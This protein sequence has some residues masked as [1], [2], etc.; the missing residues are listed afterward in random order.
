MASK[1]KSGRGRHAVWSILLLAAIALVIVLVV[2]PWAEK[3]RY[4]LAYPEQIC[5]YAEEFAL[6][7]YLV[8]AVIHCESGNRPDA[9]S[10]KGAIG[11]MQVMPETGSW[12]AE[13]LGVN[14]FETDMLKQPDLNIRFGCWYLS[15]LSNRFHSDR[16]LM[17]AAYNA[18]HRKVEQWL[19]DGTIAQDGE[20]KVFPYEETQNYVERVQ[21]AYEKYKKLYPEVL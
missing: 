17:I 12:I 2:V 11:L 21:R 4:R 5:Q 6:D 1:G 8:A 3:Q 18:G 13:K 15:F 10:A 20:I 7:P 19:E 16:R 9:V 14:D